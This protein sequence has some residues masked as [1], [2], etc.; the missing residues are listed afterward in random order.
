MT[1][2]FYVEGVC[3]SPSGLSA[4]LGQLYSDGSR[5]ASLAVVA[6]T[7]GCGKTIEELESALNMRG[8]PEMDDE[9]YWIRVEPGQ[10]LWQEDQ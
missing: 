1:S 10:V 3:A 2:R 9:A 7:E 6:I 8:H 5:G 4:A